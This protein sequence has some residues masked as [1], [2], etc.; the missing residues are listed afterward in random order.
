MNIALL[1]L[2]GNHIF[3]SLVPKFAHANKVINYR[4]ISYCIVFY[5]FIV[6]ILVGQLV[7]IANHLLHPVE[8]IFVKG[9]TITGNFHL[10]QQLLR[11]YNRKWILSRYILKVNLHKSF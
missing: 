3:I 8:A 1:H 6:K 5:K 10:A 7:D 9:S 11:S 2:E 4:P